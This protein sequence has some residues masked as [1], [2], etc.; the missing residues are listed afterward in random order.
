MRKGA[1]HSITLMSCKEVDIISQYIGESARTLFD[2]GQEHLKAHKTRNPESVLVEHELQHHQ[3]QI[4]DWS[5]EAVSFTGS[6]LVRQAKECQLIQ[7]STARLLN[8]RRE[9]GQNLPPKLT[10]DGEQTANQRRARRTNK[11]TQDIQA[12]ETSTQN[13]PDDQDQPQPYEEFPE[14]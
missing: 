1:L 3:R 13:T 14:D 11:R 12:A 10:T 2:R 7:M 5:M 9:W 6:N 8:R 4:V